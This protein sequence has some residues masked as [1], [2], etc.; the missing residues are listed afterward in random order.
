M[1]AERLAT[2]GEGIQQCHANFR[3][4]NLLS[5][6]ERFIFL[7]TLFILISSGMIRFLKILFELIYNLCF[8]V[9]AFIFCD[10][11]PPH[12][13]RVG[14]NGFVGPCEHSSCFRNRSRDTTA[15]CR[16]T[17]S[18]CCFQGIESFILQLTSCLCLACFLCVASDRFAGDSPR[19][20]LLG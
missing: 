8:L 18:S 2:V 9:S 4:P 7:L 5:R 1:E 19:K 14:H 11:V 3:L 10:R 6:K 17:F 15:F 13:A 20:A 16:N 12:S